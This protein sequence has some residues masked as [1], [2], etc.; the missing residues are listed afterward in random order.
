[1]RMILAAGYAVAAGA[2]TWIAVR[3]IESKL[4]VLLRRVETRAD[5]LETVLEREF[6]Y[7]TD[8]M[9]EIDRALQ[10]MERKR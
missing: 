3:H 8:T 1:M 4:D 2:L 10:Y 7:A 9:L 5:F 6:R